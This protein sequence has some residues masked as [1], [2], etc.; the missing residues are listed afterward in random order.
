MMLAILPVPIVGDFNVPAAQAQEPSAQSPDGELQQKLELLRKQAE[1]LSQLKK[2]ADER[3]AARK[4]KLDKA[5]AEE[6][7]AKKAA[8]E[9][10]EERKLAAE[11]AAAEREAAKQAAIQKAAAAKAAAAEKAAAE[12]AAAEKLAAEKAAAA[13]KLAAQK[14][15]AKKLAAEEKAAAEKAAAEKLAAEREDAR[16]FAIRHAAAEKAAAEQLAAEQEALKRAEAEKAAAAKEAAEQLAAE[17]AAARKAEAARLA[18][19]KQTKKDKSVQMFVQEPATDSSAPLTAEE[20]A[21]Q[22]RAAAFKEFAIKAKQQRQADAAQTQTTVQQSQSDHKQTADSAVTKRVFKKVKALP[23]DELVKT[24]LADKIADPLASAAQK[25]EK[26]K[27][28]RHGLKLHGSQPKQAFVPPPPPELVPSELGDTKLAQVLPMPGPQPPIRVLPPSSAPVVADE[29]VEPG[30]VKSAYVLERGDTVRITDYSG[31]DIHNMLGTQIATVQEDGTISVYPIGVVKAAGHTIQQL[32]E[33]INEKARKYIYEPQFLVSLMHS[34]PIVVYVLG[35]VQNPGIYTL[36]RPGEGPEPGTRAMAPPMAVAS[37]SVGNQPIT[38]GGEA[39]VE[40]KVEI[41]APLDTVLIA[42]EKAGGLRDGANIRDIRVNRPSANKVFH[43]DIWKLL[44]D[45]DASQDIEL[46]PHDSVFVP[47]GVGTFDP[48][49]LGQIAANHHRQVR[50]WGSVKTPGLYQLGPRDD[51]LS[52]IARAGGFTPNA[53]KGS[54]VLSRMNADGSLFDQRISISDALHN[55]SAVARMPLQPG[56]VIIATDNPALSMGKPLL[57]G[58]AIIGG[59]YL[60]LYLGSQIR[61]VNVTS[62]TPSNVRV[63]S[64]P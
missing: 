42:L 63:I 17:R 57:K 11:K 4:A 31:H 36:N 18:A 7:A 59:A 29:V 32:N 55:S 21:F 8:S 43:V 45:G 58:A 47:H 3:V 35:E 25:P 33:V 61:N 23:P 20:K 9:K 27:D 6:T 10:A 16:Q 30:D 1:K 12:K 60:L 56:D 44:V 46:E 54:V 51:V 37:A 40:G 48:T 41:S 19:E 39:P 53:F 64:L 62:G 49:Y 28:T 22:K 34:R 2:E 14:E 52:V 24:P 13:K 5:A 38:L 50:V 26:L 15:A